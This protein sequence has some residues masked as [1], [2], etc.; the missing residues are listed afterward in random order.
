MET[1]VKNQNAPLTPEQQKLA[2]LQ[3]EL[4][5]KQLDQI[6]ELAPY[7]KQLLD[8]AMS[9]NTRQNAYQTALDAAITPA[10]QAAA[11]AAQFKSTAALAPIQQQMAQLQLD[12]LKQGGRATDQQKADIASATDAALA[13]GTGDINTQTQRGIGMIADQLA[14]ARGLRLSDAPI[15]QEAALL[16]R[17]GNDQIASLTNNLRANQ[18]GATL[19]YPLAVQGLMSGINT[20]ASNTNQAAQQ[21]QAQLQQMAAQNR[22]SMGGAAS[23]LGLGLSNIGTN[24]S[25]LNYSSGGSSNKSAGLADYGALASGIGAL[26]LAL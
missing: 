24:G 6:N 19:N 14:N 22:A 23:G 18:A 25:A 12:A 20:N 21:F 7:Q 3:A 15:G 16:T 1:T 17:A 10:D 9:N 4:A 26:M 8:Y 11:Q 2:G 13:A 5:Q